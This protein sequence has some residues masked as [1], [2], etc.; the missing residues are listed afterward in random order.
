MVIVRFFVCLFLNTHTICI[1]LFREN[2]NP[3]LQAKMTAFKVIL[4]VHILAITDTVFT[5]LSSSEH[6]LHFKTVQKLEEVLSAAKEVNLSEA[7]DNQPSEPADI[8]ISLLL[9]YS[10]IHLSYFFYHAFSTPNLFHLIITIQKL[11]C[12]LSVFLSMPTPTL[13]SSKV[14]LLQMNSLPDHRATDLYKV[15]DRYLQQEA[16]GM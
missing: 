3:N 4:T 7:Y 9:F 1:E 14:A 10:W 8:I 5:W 12:S 16:Q 6:D 11:R 2:V 13:P 15:G